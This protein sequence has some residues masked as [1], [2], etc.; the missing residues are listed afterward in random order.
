MAVPIG[1]MG[2]GLSAYPYG[3]SVPQ[4]IHEEVL[5]AELVKRGGRVER[6]LELVGCEEEGEEGVLARL[7]NLNDGKEDMFMASYIAGCDGPHSAVRKLAGIELIGGTY[8]REFFVA[9]VDVDGDIAGSNDMN[10]CFTGTDFCLYVPLQQRSGGARLVG[11]VPEGINEDEV[12]FEHV[13]PTIKAG[14][15]LNVTRVGWFST[16]KVHHRVADLFRKGRFILLGDAAHLHSPVGGQGMN[17]GLGDASNLAWK[18]ARVLRGSEGSSIDLLETYHVERIK[19]AKALVKTTDR[20][21]TLITHPGLLGKFIR[22]IFVPYIWPLIF[23]Y[24]G[25]PRFA[26]KRLS[27]I[28]IEYRESALSEGSAGQVHAGDRLPWV[29]FDDGSENHSVLSSLR[30]QAHVYGDPKS[31]LNGVATRSLK[32]ILEANNIRL[33]VFPWSKAAE[34]AGLERDAVYLVRP[35]GHVG[36]ACVVGSEDVALEEYLKRLGPV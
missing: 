28:M 30:W 16:Y 19:F 9:D 21:F 8:T 27:Q 14:S 32:E 34:V 15:G 4:D 25:V 26:F 11:I 1:D 6:G 36:M 24:P 31:S 20:W 10:V 22:N 3:L 7:R 18:L 35:D 29:R 33:H 2:E 13:A 12:R 17:T 23:K 5:E